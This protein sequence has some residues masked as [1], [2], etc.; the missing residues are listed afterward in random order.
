M[1]TMMSN[2]V[3][4]KAIGG[5]GSNGNNERYG[6]QAKLAMS[7]AILGCAAALA[8]GRPQIGDAMQSRLR[9][10]TQAVPLA[11]G[12]LDWEQ[13]ERVQVAPSG[14][15]QL[16]EISTSGEFRWAFDGTINPSASSCVSAD[17]SGVPGEGCDLTELGT[18][19]KLPDLWN[20]PV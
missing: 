18:A 12:L 20:I 19:K 6:L 9:P 2:Q 1:V 15:Q 3:T 8:F 10:I 7:A 11:T 5:Q 4:G 17:S 14:A 13:R 16:A